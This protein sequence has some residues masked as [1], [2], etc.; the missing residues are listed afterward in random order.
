MNLDFRTIS[1]AEIAG[2][3][4]LLQRAVVTDR[5]FWMIWKTCQDKSV[6]DTL[7]LRKE[8]GAWAAY[9]NIPRDSSIK[10]PPLPATYVLKDSSRLLPYQYRAVAGLTRSFIDHGCA[11]DGSEIGKSYAALGVCREVG[12]RPGIICRKAGISGWMRACAHMGVQPYFVC[13]WEMARTG[14]FKPIRR[15]HDAYAPIWH[16]RWA[17]PG[18][19]FMAIVDEVHMACNDDTLNNMLFRGFR[20]QNDPPIPFLA[21]SATLA[22]RPVR[23]TTLM[24]MLGI[25]NRKSYLSWLK[26]RGAFENLQGETESLSSIEDM[27]EINKVLYPRYGARL[28][29][30]DPD[31][32][33]FFPEC[34]YQVELVDLGKQ[35][36]RM[37]N[38]EYLSLVKKVY[39]YRKMG[40]THAE[41]RV[42]ELRFRQAVE[43]QKVST[44][45]ELAQDYMREGLSVCIFVNFRETLAALAQVLGTK[46]L[47]FGEQERYHLSRE[48]VMADFQSNAQR[49]IV[50][51][52]D[53]GGQSIDLH[54]LHGGHRRISLICPTY[55]PITLKQVLGRTRRAG[56]RT[57]PIMKLIYAAGTVEEKV[58]RNVALKLDSIEAL[59][60]GDLME[61]DLF[62]L[63]G[64]AE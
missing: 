31:V 42:A 28:S 61:P 19:D 62:N 36:V 54:D 1:T 26:S 33:A 20:P 38:K 10:L 17:S 4:C 41:P 32:K 49:L 23:L 22:D 47:I 8:N 5:Y 59:N 48:K 55:N 35:A 15:F 14:K 60:K 16:Y 3:P 43:L 30:D 29:Y 39:E 21:L 64:G 11:A 52:S 27:K 57:T 50:A 18:K 63:T 12:M 40:A 45:A 44:M 34:V 2:V 56:S 7:M 25:A 53:A 9:R 46:S 24:E 6:K 37:M 58:A 13:N 51:M